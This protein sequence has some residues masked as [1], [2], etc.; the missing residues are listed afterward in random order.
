MKNGHAYTFGIEEEFFLVDPASRDLVADVPREFLRNCRRLLGERVHEEM[1]Q[2]QVEIAT[3]V[4]RDAGQARG[5]L[6]EL[7]ASVGEIAGALDMRLVAAGT[8]PFAA[9]REHAGTEAPRYDRLL[10]DFQIVGRRNLVCGLHVHVEVPDGVDRVE[11]MNRLMPWTP[12]LLALSTSSPFW[13][14]RATGLM[15]YRQAAYDEWPRSGVP[16]AF[17]DEARYAEFIDLLATCGAL[18]NGSFLWWAMRPSARFPTLE[19]RITDACTRLEDSLALAAAFRCLVR[20]HVRNPRLGQERSSFT[21]RLI[22]ENRWRAKRFGVRADFIDE[23]RRCLVPLEERLGELLELVAPDAVALDCQAE[24]R[25]LRMVQRLGTSAD[26]QMAMY[27][28]ERESLCTRE[29]ALARV[30]DWLAEA[31][32]AGATLPFAPETRPRV[33]HSGSAAAAAKA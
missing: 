7:R 24:L 5:T 21:R 16:D 18:E 30:V 29:Q 31:T 8:H 15:S 32:A 2:A 17:E 13:D 3:P 19:L 12:L 26:V 20:A 4:L 14:G 9:W 22:D 11:L 33:L 28:R 27:R 25:Q 1:K 6:A 10:S 23:S